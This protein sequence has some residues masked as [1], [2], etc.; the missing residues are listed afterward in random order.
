MSEVLTY[1]DHQVSE[2]QKQLIPHLLQTLS[3]S[4]DFYVE[5]KWEFTSWVPFV[6]RVCPSDTYK[7]WKAGKSIRVDSTLTGS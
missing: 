2:E 1:R 6:S 5:M 3:K 7:V 4:A